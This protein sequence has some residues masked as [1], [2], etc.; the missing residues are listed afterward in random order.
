[1]R[2]AKQKPELIDSEEEAW[3]E[4]VGH[5][6]ADETILPLRSF[7]HEREMLRGP[8]VTPKPREKLR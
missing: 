4:S 3:G 8:D 7:K 1:M 6:E 5:A 2:R